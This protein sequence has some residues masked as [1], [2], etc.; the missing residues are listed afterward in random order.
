MHDKDPTKL[1][2]TGLFLP[3]EEELRTIDREA[4]LRLNETSLHPYKDLAFL[5]IRIHQPNRVLRRVPE[6]EDHL[7]AALSGNDDES[8]LQAVNSYREARRQLAPVNEQPI[9]AILSLA[10]YVNTL[11]QHI[12]KYPPENAPLRRADAIITFLAKGVANDFTDDQLLDAKMSSN[13]LRALLEHPGSSA[14]PRIHPAIENLTFE[15]AKRHMTSRYLDALPDDP[16]TISSEAAILDSTHT[17]ELFT[18]IRTTQHYGVKPGYTTD[19]TWG[20][21]IIFHPPVDFYEVVGADADLLHPLIRPV[22]YCAFET[23]P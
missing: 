10:T 12:E 4:S 9:N 21:S 3:S 23:I 22:N 14:G 8:I 18:H 11:N 7:A 19:A 1:I 2:P 17:R 16:T 13:I 6:V 15:L 5:D 20:G